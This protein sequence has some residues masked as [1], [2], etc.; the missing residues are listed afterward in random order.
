VAISEPDIK[1]LWGKAAGRCSYPACG[2]DCLPFLDVDDPTIIGEMAHVI[3][4]STDGPRGKSTGGN[5]SYSNLILL[6]PTHHTLV[7][8]A[9]GGKFTSEML[10]EWKTEHERRIEASL[11]APIFPDRS[12]LDDF[13]SR[14]LIENRACWSTYGPESNAAK[15]N[16]NSTA[17]LFWSFRKLTLIVPNNRQIISAVRSNSSLFSADE[18]RTTCSFVEHAEG[19]ERNCITP[20]EGVP[21]FPRQFGEMFND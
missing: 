8:K 20:T 12:Q 15:S 19:F 7:D 10:H 9:P 6:C 17:G 1:R 4:H 11:A 3:A 5:D 13:I 21:R 16:P 18:Y 14:R 2:V